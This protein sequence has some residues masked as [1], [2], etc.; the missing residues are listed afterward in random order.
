MDSPNIFP[1]SDTFSGYPTTHP[2]ANPVRIR[3]ISFP[4]QVT[5]DGGLKTSEDLN[6]VRD[7]I[8]HVLYTMQGERIMRPAFGITDSTFEVRG[9]FTPIYEGIRAA[10]TQQVKNVDSFSVSGEFAPPS[11]LRIQ[12]NWI[13]KSFPQNPLQFELAL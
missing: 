8:F 1:N 2:I 9:N 13:V 7:R 10:L 5:E 6:L 4:L 3:G 11:T 12:I